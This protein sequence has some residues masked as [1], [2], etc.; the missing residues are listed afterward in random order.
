MEELRNNKTETKTP[1]EVMLGMT[2]DGLVSAR[3]L[4][5]FLELAPSQFSRWCKDNITESDLAIEGE[6][7]FLSRHNVE[8]AASGGKVEYID[9]LLPIK[10]AKD[11]CMTCRTI[12]SRQVRDY[13]EKCEKA[14]VVTT[15]EYNL[16]KDRVEQLGALVENKFKLLEETNQLAIAT[17][18]RLESAEGGST[19]AV[20]HDTQWIHDNYLRVKRLAE[21]RG[22]SISDCLTML[23][24]EM[25]ESGQLDYSYAEMARDYKTHHPGQKA[26]R[27]AVLAQDLDTQ[28]AF[29][30]ILE[31]QMDYWDVFDE[32]EKKGRALLD[33]F[34]DDMELEPMPTHEHYVDTEDPGFLAAMDALNEMHRKEEEREKCH[35]ME[36]EF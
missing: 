25:D 7:Y 4:Y 27:L 15:K 1:I 32:R 13:F 28:M 3:K 31:G 10:F 20:D 5:E 16:L 26:E 14:L 36:S 18:A 33:E 8:L 9:Y 29:E 22:M 30:Y 34:A 17:A 35:N 6:D 23:V 21:K 24:D 11:L 2:E 12:K 19:F